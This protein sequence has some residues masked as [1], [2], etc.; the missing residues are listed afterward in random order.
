MNKCSNKHPIHDKT[1]YINQVACG[2]IKLLERIE[3]DK[4]NDNKN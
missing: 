3:R 4:I 1:F 2:Y